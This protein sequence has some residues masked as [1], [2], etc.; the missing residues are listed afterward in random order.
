MTDDLDSL[1]PSTAIQKYLSEL[2]QELVDVIVQSHHYHFKQFVQWCEREPIDNLNDL[3]GREI[4]RF[5]I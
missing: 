2:R 5:W 3:Y 4:H 1:Y